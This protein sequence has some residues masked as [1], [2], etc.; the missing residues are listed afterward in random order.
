MTDHRR[1]QDDAAQIAAQS[2]D[3]S[4]HGAHASASVPGQSGHHAP[5]DRARVV[6]EV[7]DDERVRG[8]D[9]VTIAVPRGD[10]EALEEVRQRLSTDAVT[11]AGATVIV[12]AHHREGQ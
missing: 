9:R 2:I 1:D 11:S 12:Q 6:D 5:G 8:A 7:L 10:S 3:V 4:E